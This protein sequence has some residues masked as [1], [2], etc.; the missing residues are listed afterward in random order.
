[1]DADGHAVLGSQSLGEPV[2]VVVAMGQH[3]RPDVLDRAAHGRQLG[4]QVS[5][6]RGHARVDEGDR[7]GLLHEV[8]ADDLFAE[9]MQGWGESHGS[10]LL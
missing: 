8:A 5:V 7:S 1:M 2:V 10:D 3:E 9:P 6:V 4:R